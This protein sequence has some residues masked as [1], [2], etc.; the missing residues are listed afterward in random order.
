[1]NFNGIVPGRALNGTRLIHYREAVS[2]R[3]FSTSYQFFDTLYLKI[4]SIPLRKIPKISIGLAFLDCAICFS[5]FLND[6]LVV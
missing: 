1:V 6:F 4:I 3:N 2:Y 5:Y